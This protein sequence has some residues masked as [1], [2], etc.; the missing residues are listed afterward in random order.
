MVDPY[1]LAFQDALADLNAARPAA[2]QQILC[3]LS[4]MD[5]ALVHAQNPELLLDLVLRLAADSIVARHDVTGPARAEYRRTL[6]LIS[7]KLNVIA[8][9]EASDSEL[10]TYLSKF[11]LRLAEFDE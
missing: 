5:F 3:R 4:E 8:P 7:R 11:D 10:V 9:S 2:P 6:E 1:L